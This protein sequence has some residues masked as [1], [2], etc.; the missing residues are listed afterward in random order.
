MTR[1]I[2]RPL[3][4]IA[5]AVALHALALTLALNNGF[6]L[7]RTPQAVKPSEAPLFVVDFLPS[8]P[9]QEVPEPD[10]VVDVPLPVAPPT[11]APAFLPDAPAI[12]APAETAR[13]PESRAAPPAPT[14]EEWAFAAGYTLK[15]SKAYRYTWGQQVRSSMGTAVEGPESGVVRFRVEIAPDG[16]LA[17]LDTLWTTSAS[18]EQRARQAIENLPP[19]P[20]TPT[21]KPLVFEKTISFSPFV[22]DVPPIYR[23]D[24][25][26][27]PPSFRNRFAWSGV[28]QPAQADEPS[29]DEAEA[30][31]LED[32]L[33]LL[34]RD[35]IEAE[36]AHDQEQ[37]NRWGSRTLGQ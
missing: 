12:E 28:G 17:S 18:I 1:P 22:T 24:C 7:S 10:P 27:D 15:N 32:C 8:A 13:Q 21:G 2:N 36:A 34:P 31:P 19:S 14:A 6:R 25:L 4:A 16:R 35:S 37:L 30:M 20:P 11:S 5:L 23:N 3:L 29:G 9:Q 26:P 33:K